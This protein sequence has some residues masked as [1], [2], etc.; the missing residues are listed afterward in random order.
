MRVPEA[1]DF[2]RPSA[3][4]L[5]GIIDVSEEQNRWVRGKFTLEPTVVVE[6]SFELAMEAKGFLGTNVTYIGAWRPIASTHKRNQPPVIEY[7]LGKLVARPSDDDWSKL[8]KPLIERLGSY[9]PPI[10]SRESIIA[11]HR[12]KSR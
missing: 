12:H 7:Q 6:M 8:I 2:L 9:Y 5:R 11:L 4:K 1:F 10:V 3:Q